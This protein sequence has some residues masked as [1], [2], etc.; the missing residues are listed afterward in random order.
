MT[1]TRIENG[2]PQS[3]QAELCVV[4]LCLASPVISVAGK[5]MELVMNV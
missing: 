2:C 5:P 1:T 4:Q 3:H